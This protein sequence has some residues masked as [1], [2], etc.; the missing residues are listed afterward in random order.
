M[1]RGETQIEQIRRL[2]GH[3][4]GLAQD[5]NPDFRAARTAWAQS[6]RAETH[7]AGQLRKLC[8]NIE[9]IISGGVVEEN[10][11]D[12]S[13]IEQMLLAYANLI[14][15]WA[16]TTAERML[17]DV[18]QRGRRQWA[19]HSRM[20]SRAIREEIE[21]APTGSILRR[22]QDEQVTLIKSL[23]LQAAQRVHDIAIRGITEGTRGEDIVADIMQTGHVAMSRAVCI[24]RTETSRAASNLT[25]ARAEYIGS[26][27][28]IWRTASDADVRDDHKKLNGKTFEW[29]NPPV[30][31]KRSGATAHPGCIYN[32]RCYSEPLIHE[33]F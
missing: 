8:R 9:F 2:F 1:L 25:Q 4:P 22:L 23:P 5:R 12:T 6:R 14:T 15:P 32:C 26:T 29:N 30:A 19:Q 21:R 27:K 3:R 24:A 17:R 10:P 11:T 18:D 33:N 31:D 20:M 16:E 7:Y 28:Y 13:A